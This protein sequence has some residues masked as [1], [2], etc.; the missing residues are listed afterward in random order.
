MEGFRKIANDQ[1]HFLVLGE[2]AENFWNITEK[3]LNQKIVL[4]K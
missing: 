2:H 1:L 4:D 3:L